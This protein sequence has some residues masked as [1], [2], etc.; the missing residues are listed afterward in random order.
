M[1]FVKPDGEAN[2]TL[3]MILI[4]GTS[5]E[6]IESTMRRVSDVEAKELEAGTIVIKE[7]PPC[8][9][10]K[11]FHASWD[12]SVS[13][14]LSASL[15]GCQLVDLKEKSWPLKEDRAYEKWAAKSPI[16]G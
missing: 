7:S 9:S 4:G 8:C 13:L 10:D 14:H 12:A 15:W 5:M 2:G 1:H 16:L 6:S 3:H 11:D